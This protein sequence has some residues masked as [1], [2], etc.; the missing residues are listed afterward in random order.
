MLFY[1]KRLKFFAQTGETVNMP[2]QMVTPLLVDEL[3]YILNCLK[4]SIG[5]YFK[6]INDD[7]F[8]IPKFIQVITLTEQTCIIYCL[9]EEKILLCSFGEKRM[10]GCEWFYSKT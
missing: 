1:E 2:G 3:K 8:R 9:M 10:F 5:K 4:K 6:M 7:K